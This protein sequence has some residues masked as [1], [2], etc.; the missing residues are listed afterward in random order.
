MTYQLQNESGNPVGFD[1]FESF[2]LYLSFQVT[3]QTRVLQLSQRSYFAF[4]TTATSG[5]R[6]IASPSFGEDPTVVQ[7]ANYKLVNTAGAR[8]LQLNSLALV[9]TRITEL[10]NEFSQLNVF[11]FVP[12]QGGA[13]MPADSWL[14]DG[15][16]GGG[17]HVPRRVNERPDDPFIPHLLT[18]D[19]CSA[20]DC[21][22]F[23]SR[24]NQK[25]LQRLSTVLPFDQGSVFSSLL[26]NVGKPMPELELKI[27]G[28]SWK[29]FDADPHPD[30][31]EGF[32]MV[33][34]G[35][36]RELS[37]GRELEQWQKLPG[38]GAEVVDTLTDI[39]E[40]RNRFRRGPARGW[41][42][43][44]STVEASDDDTNV[45]VDSRDPVEVLYLDFGDLHEVQ[46][47]DPFR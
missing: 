21:F 16:W 6:N 28:N 40:R 15:S 2:W 13:G 11:R 25:G 47:I 8:E 34:A 42:R 4:Y 22:W 37:L 38:G 23:M 24:E 45:E 17:G 10:S 12:Q 29:A 9:E 7:T 43:S 18:F 33:C 46:P 44:L 39:V 5:Y 19:K 20:R 27:K 41:E 26:Q 1:S 14:N 35:A 36:F 32:A 3:R 30:T 31:T